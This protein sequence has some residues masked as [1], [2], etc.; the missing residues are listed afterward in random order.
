MPLPDALRSLDDRVLGARRRRAVGEPG[1]S[2]QRPARQHH[3]GPADAADDEHRAGR[4][5]RPS[6][7]GVREVLGVVRTVA[8]LVFL[9]L[10]AL[11]AL[12]IAL[13]F[14]PTNDDNALVRNGLELARWATGPFEDVL[15]AASERRAVLYNH[16][17]AT[18]V[19]LL[20]AL[21]V[22]KLPGPRAAR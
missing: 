2:D 19:Y 4:P 3:A 16:G 17:L 18:A 5:R 7:D 13:T 6:G 22:T 12:G 11:T 1:G 9:A 15:T 14:L 21:L 8:K 10:A 20:A